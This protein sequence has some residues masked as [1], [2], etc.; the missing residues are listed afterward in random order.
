MLSWQLSYWLVIGE[1][2]NPYAAW[3]FSVSGYKVVSIF[4]FKNSSLLPVT[5]TLCETYCSGK[6]K[7][8]LSAGFITLN[9]LANWK[10]WPEILFP[11]FNKEDFCVLFS[12]FTSELEISRTHCVNSPLTLIVGT[13]V[14]ILFFDIYLPIFD[15]T[16]EISPFGVNVYPLSFAAMAASVTNNVSG[17]SAKAT[18][19]DYL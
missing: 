10:N 14:A 4:N 15:L 9:T 17:T 8:L 5:T 18:S 1:N 19:N 16:L 2:L 12:S 7:S 11:I 13:P 6:N 3:V